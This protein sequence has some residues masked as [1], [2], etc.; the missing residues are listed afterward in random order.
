M[1]RRAGTVQSGPQYSA[2]P[3]PS[4]A[5]R[6]ARNIGTGTRSAGAGAGL[7]PHD[8]NAF[9]GSPGH[10]SV[11]LAGPGMGGV[12][13]PWPPFTRPCQRGCNI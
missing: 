6:W 4:V 1:G 3:A 2:A 12:V 13:S 5:S 10:G 9:R 7:N 11:L 8:G